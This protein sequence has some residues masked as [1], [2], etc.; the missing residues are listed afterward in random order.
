MEEPFHI[1]SSFTIQGRTLSGLSA[2]L[3]TGK[4]NLLDGTLI[5]TVEKNEDV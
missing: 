3:T 5:T 4:N 2:L 1:P